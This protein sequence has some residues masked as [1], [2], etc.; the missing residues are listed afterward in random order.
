MNA[1][2]GQQWDA[3]ALSTKNGNGNKQHMAAA[4]LWIISLTTDEDIWSTQL[5]S[6]NFFY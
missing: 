2:R 1:T 5:G 4:F 6:T 3:C